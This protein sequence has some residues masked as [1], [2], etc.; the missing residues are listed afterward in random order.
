[1]RGVGARG[2]EEE[3]WMGSGRGHR[4]EIEPFL[5]IVVW[6]CRGCVFWID[7]MGETWVVGRWRRQQV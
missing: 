4:G 3:C 6:V 7:E 2:V 5:S 1:V